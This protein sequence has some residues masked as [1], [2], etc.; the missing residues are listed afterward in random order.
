[1]GTSFQRYH[2]DTTKRGGSHDL[3]NEN[4]LEK[5]FVLRIRGLCYCEGQFRGRTSRVRASLQNWL[6]GH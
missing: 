2:S 4:S 5:V 1:M 6:L 3:S